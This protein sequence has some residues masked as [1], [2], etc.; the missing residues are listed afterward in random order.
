MTSSPSGPTAAT[1]PLI[2]GSL[3][4][5]APFFPSPLAVAT[6]VG[7]STSR[8]PLAPLGSA[9]TRA[10][11]SEPAAHPRAALSALA[12]PV[13]GCVLKSARGK[14]AIALDRAGRDA[15]A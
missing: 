15:T 7:A 1:T 9:A 6:A 4:S 12:A 11:T 3:S 8:P 5:A 13:G 2:I 14:K 10:A